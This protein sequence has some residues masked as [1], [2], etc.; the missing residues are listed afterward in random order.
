MPAKRKS[1]TLDSLETACRKALLARSSLAVTAIGGANGAFVEWGGRG[2]HIK[3]TL[4]NHDHGLRPATIHELLHVILE[5]ELQS[6]NKDLAE[7]VVLAFERV[8]NKRICASRRRLTWWRKTVDAK[9]PKR[10]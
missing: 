7:E 1:W 9:L 10:R 2:G 6:F 4:D 5:E 8:L 3:A